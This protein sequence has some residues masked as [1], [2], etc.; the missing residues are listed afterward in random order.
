MSTWGLRQK[1]QPVPNLKG[2]SAAPCGYAVWNDLVVGINGS[3]EQL[4]LSEIMFE[5]IMYGEFHKCD[6]WS[7]L[8]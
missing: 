6:I 3:D 1:L 8:G 2:Y 5:S 4:S 7:V